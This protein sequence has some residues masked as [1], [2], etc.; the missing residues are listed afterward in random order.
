MN[1]KLTSIRLWVAF[2]EA[3]VRPW[4]IIAAIPLAY[5][6]HPGR[7]VVSDPASTPASLSAS[8]SW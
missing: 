8:L 2:G 1:D 4:G 3:C 5:G 6:S 7:T